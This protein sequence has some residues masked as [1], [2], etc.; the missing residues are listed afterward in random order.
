MSAI[1]III[2]PALVRSGPAGVSATKFT[3]REKKKAKKKRKIR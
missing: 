1:R 2:P 3:K